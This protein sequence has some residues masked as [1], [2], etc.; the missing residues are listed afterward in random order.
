MLMP[1]TAN[2]ELP[3]NVYEAERIGRKKSVVE[4]VGEAAELTTVPD[5]EKTKIPLL[6][7]GVEEKT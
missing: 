1:E 2:T 7:N 3:D 6:E 4:A 5:R